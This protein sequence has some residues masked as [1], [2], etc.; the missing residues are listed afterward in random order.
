[1]VLCSCS[2]FHLSSLPVC[3]RDL[4]NVLLPC[5]ACPLTQP[6]F[7]KSIHLDFSH[8][9]YRKLLE[10]FNYRIT[11]MPVSVI[12]YV[13]GIT[14]YIHGKALKMVFGTFCWHINFHFWYFSRQKKKI[15]LWNLFLF[16]H[17]PFPFHLKNIGNSV[18]SLTIP[19]NFLL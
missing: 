19:Y 17:L 10:P 2:V 4:R 5:K 9:S 12:N 13:A 7:H 3:L 1:M 11:R 14:L 6:T 8:L 18:S 16:L 15:Y